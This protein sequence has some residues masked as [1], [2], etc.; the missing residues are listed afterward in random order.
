MLDEIVVR[1]LGLIGEASVRLADGLTV[2]TGETGTGKTLMLGALRLLRGDKAGKGIIG[3]AST[4]CD[5][6]GRLVDGDTETTIRRTV[7]ASRSR[8]YID[9][10]A[11]T[12]GT[13]ADTLAGVVAIVGQHDQLTITTPT[14]VRTLVDRLLDEEGRQVAERYSQAWVAYRI[15]LGEAD[16]IGGDLHSLERERDTLSF[17]IAEIDD[18]AIDPDVDGDLRHRVI[19]LRN[20]DALMADVDRALRAL[21]D[22]GVE[23]H[24]DAAI[25][26]LD[27][28]S[29]ID[30]GVRALSDR[31]IDATTSLRDAVSDIA[32]FGTGLEADPSALEAL[33]DRIALINGLMRKYGDSIDDIAL[34]RDQAAERHGRLSDLLDAAS[35]IEQRVGAAAADVARVGADLT[36]ARRRAAASMADAATRH[37]R[38]LGFT[39]PV[40]VIAIE[41]SEPNRHGCDTTSVRWAST[42]GLTPQP[43]S[44]IASGGELSRLVLAL[45]LASGSDEAT[46][47]A[48]DEIDTGI[49][50][51]TALA[52]G[53][54]LNALAAHRQVVV[55]SHLPQVAAFADEH[56]VVERRGANATV[57]RLDDDERLVELTRMLSGMSESVVGREHAAELVTLA[58]ASR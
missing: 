8:A 19:R 29:K 58:R 36:E 40:V 30:P 51:A 44:A 31:L 34:F 35:D 10:A 9:G 42:E 7:D 21:G 49:G 23:A 33:E 53:Q 50:G 37:L 14:G 1:N 16:E 46:V 43:V 3:P 2:I 47:L 55:V 26:A 20:A 4:T 48:F 54:K 45:T 38:D 17:Q 18:A 5:V 22:D 15:V 32:A 56:F 39:S 13:L 25:E 6:S 24:L 41:A 12:A 52:M 27:A 11:A 28:A 57:R